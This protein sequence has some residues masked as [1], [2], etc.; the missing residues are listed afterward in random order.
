MF[1]KNK[2]N[3]NYIINFVKNMKKIEYKLKEL[4]YKYKNNTNQNLINYMNKTFSQPKSGIKELPKNKKN[5]NLN[6]LH[7]SKAFHR[8]WSSQNIYGRNWDYANKPIRNNLYSGLTKI[9]R[10]PSVQENRYEIYKLM[11]KERSKKMN[12][13]NNIYN[14]I[15]INESRL[16]REKL[17]LSGFKSNNY[18]T[19][20]KVELKK[21]YIQVKILKV[22]LISKIVVKQLVVIIIL[23]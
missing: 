19:K 8:I 17:Y 16:Y 9:Y 5:I 11:K 2:N 23:Y 13:L 21:K 10:A 7:S 3:R 22:L 20:R 18:N 1:I 6:E 15:M 14:T 4:S 12:Y